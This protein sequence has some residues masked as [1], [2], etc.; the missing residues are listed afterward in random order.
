MAATDRDRERAKEIYANMSRRQKV[1]YFLTYYKW[2]VLIIIVAIVL[3]IMWIWHI[4]HPDPDVLANVTLVSAADPSV[5]SDGTNVF[6]RYLE[7]EGYDPDEE[8]LDVVIMTESTYNVELISAKLIT[9]EIDLVAGEEDTR[10]LLAQSEALAALDLMLPDDLLDEYADNLY[11]DTDSETGEEHAYA[12][13]IKDD[14]P[15]IYE[16]YYAE[17]VWLGI[18][19]TSDNSEV[20]ESVLEYILREQ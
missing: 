3:L 10:K 6:D 17:P 8:T 14:N 19:A 15:L 16:G 20:A 9:G 5:Y 2:V 4:T 13:L 12:V 1:G 11:M 7:D 18:A